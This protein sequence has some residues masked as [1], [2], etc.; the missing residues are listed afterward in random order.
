MVGSKA[1][2]DTKMLNAETEK[3]LSTAKSI[4]NNSS[5]LE[6]LHRNN[7]YNQKWL[8]LMEPD[9]EHPNGKKLS[10]HGK[11]LKELDQTLFKIDLYLTK[12]ELSPD[13]QSCIY[14]KLSCVPNS[15]GNLKHLR[16]LKLDTNELHSLPAEIGNLVHLE[17]L[18]LS[19]NC[20]KSLPDVMANLKNLKSLHLSKNAFDKVPACIFQMSS[21]IYLD[22]TTN[23]L[24][25][26]DPQ[27]AKLGGSLKFLSFYDNSIES[28][29]PWLPDLTSLEQIWL[30]CNQ[31]KQVP[32]EV[33]HM[34]NL[35]WEQNYLTIILDNNP[36]EQPPLTVCRKGFSAIK[37]WYIDNNLI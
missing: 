33:I 22:M 12:L 32:Y 36:M 8:N 7:Y 11:D 25:V 5:R 2:A 37:N 6:L 29:S 9:A 26:I 18:S 27:I 3:M 24:R 31:I 1:T 28:L 16:E 15:I 23:K 4:N 17:R 19:N 35:D 21:L 34:K 10:I 13:Y 14:Y 30:G 20:L